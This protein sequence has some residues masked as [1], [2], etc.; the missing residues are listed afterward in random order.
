MSYT[1]QDVFRFTGYDG[2]Q[3]LQLFRES[4]PLPSTGE[5]IVKVRS[6]ALNYRD[7]PIA[8][9]TYPVPMTENIIPSC[10]M[11][12]EVIAIGPSTELFR[13]ITLNIGDAVVAPVGASWLYGT[14]NER[15]SGPNFASSAGKQGGM[16]REF[17]TIPAHSLVKLPP[18]NGPR[19]FVRWPTTPYTVS[20][21]WNAVYGPVP[22]SRG[23]TIMILGKRCFVKD[24]TL[25]V[26]GDSRPVTYY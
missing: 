4:V 8:N 7:V 13:P 25:H 18:C 16:L 17:L 26:C 15:T 1:V 2:F 9:S 19:D 23:D 5:V 3:N 20:T 12:G 24:R 21:V 10:D 11:A 6:V 14:T 22:L